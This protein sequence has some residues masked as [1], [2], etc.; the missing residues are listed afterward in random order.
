MKKVF[1]FVIFLVALVS[2]SCSDEERVSEPEVETEKEIKV[3]VDKKIDELVRLYP[4]SIDNEKLRSE[5]PYQEII[6]RQDEALNYMLS[7]FASGKAQGSRGDIMMLACRDIL[8][9]RDSVEGEVYSGI[10]WYKKFIIRKE[11][12]LDN[13]EYSGRDKILKLVY[14][15]LSQ[16]SDTVDYQKEGFHVSGIKVYKTVEEGSYLKVFVHVLESN[17]KLFKGEEDQ[18]ILDEIGGSSIPCAITFKKDKGDKYKLDTMDKPKDGTEYAA[19]IEE[20][21]I[22]PVTNKK[23]GGLANRLINNQN[24]IEYCKKILFDNLKEHLTKNGIKKA[25]L[26]DPYGAVDFKMK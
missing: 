18:Y 16:Y 6:K 2:V 10:D 20:F 23:I 13:F 3:I 17:Y 8:G 21:C 24:D 12:P 1:M 15:S 4:E 9:D 7:E 22:T 19:S 25:I 14:D 5:T 26:Y 11:I